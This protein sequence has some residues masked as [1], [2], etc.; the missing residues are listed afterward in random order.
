[1]SIVELCTVAVERNLSVRFCIRVIE[2]QSIR[3]DHQKRK[4]NHIYPIA[5][6]VVEDIPVALVDD[7]VVAVQ[8]ADPLA[9]CHLQS[10]IPCSPRPPILLRDDLE[11]FG[12]LLL[13]L[14]QDGGTAVGRAVVYTDDLVLPH[15]QPLA[16]QGVE[17]AGKELLHVI[18]GN[19]DG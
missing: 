14:C 13:I 6:E 7:V 4:G 5:T 17:A 2:R 18:D 9:T 3:I 1:M 8:E 19:N 12:V 15:F 11:H 16:Q 10:C